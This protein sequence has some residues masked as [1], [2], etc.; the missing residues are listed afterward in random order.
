MNILTG[1]ARLAKDAEVRVTQGGLS[2]CLFSAAMD[3]GFG[4][5][6]Y[7]VWLRMSIFPQSILS[8]SRCL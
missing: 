2:I 5:S 3:S 1:T 8:I 7:P 6:K 4:D